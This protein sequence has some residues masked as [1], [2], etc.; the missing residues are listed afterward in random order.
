ML[1]QATDL[2]RQ[3]FPQVREHCAREERVLAPSRRGWDRAGAPALSPE[4]GE[5]PVAPTPRT[6]QEG[7]HSPPHPCHP[8][9]SPTYLCPGPG[10]PRRGAALRLAGLSAGGDGLWTQAGR[11]PLGSVV[12][13]PRALDRPALRALSARAAAGAPVPHRPAAGTGDAVRGGAASPAGGGRSGAGASTGVN[14]PPAAS[15]CAV[16]RPR[17]RSP[18]PRP[19]LTS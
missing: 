19:L 5:T 14:F 6:A 2:F 17:V 4:A 12:R 11:D 3:P 10:A 16:L 8:T 1:L 18:R 13:A 9:P 15:V 7:P